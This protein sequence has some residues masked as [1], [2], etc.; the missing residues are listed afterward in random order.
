[1]KLIK[2]NVNKL[3]DDGV[4][5]RV[6]TQNFKFKFPYKVNRLYRKKLFF[7]KFLIL[8]ILTLLAF[9]LHSSEEVDDPT[10]DRSNASQICKAENVQSYECTVI[11]FD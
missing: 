1:M 8:L 3:V 6:I 11:V 10:R 5:S 7:S 2:R 4:N 9:S